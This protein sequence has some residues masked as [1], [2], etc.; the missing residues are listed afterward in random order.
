MFGNRE[1]IL[2]DLWRRHMRR[3]EFEAAWQLSDSLLDHHAGKQDLPPPRHLQQV[4]HGSPLNGKRVLVK[5]YH[6]LGDTIQFIRYTPLLKEI[7]AEVIVWAQPALIPLLATARGIDRLLRLHD[8]E[9]EIDYDLDVEIMEL[10]HVFRTRL[11]TVP[12]EIP[13]LHVEPMA[14]PFTEALKVGVCWRAGDWDDRRSIPFPLLARLA[15]IPGITWYIHQRGDGLAERAE[16][17]G[18]KPVFHNLLEEA[19]AM[20]SLDLFISVDTMPAHLAGALAVPV[21]NLLHAEADWRWMEGRENSPWYPTM[22]LFRQAR[23]GEWEP[24]I[25]RVAAEL[26]TLSRYRPLT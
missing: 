7:A 13:Y 11:S 6:G 14:M 25:A 8:G 4:W 2:I 18:V 12:A 10:P 21:W 1:V 20:R 16:R 17:F 3:G 26:K 24:V 19:R 22:R 9:P 15:E 5:C 23:R